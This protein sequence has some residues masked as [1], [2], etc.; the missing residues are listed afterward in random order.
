MSLH[1]V[2]SIALTIAL[3]A[4]AG[5]SHRGASHAPVNALDDT[6]ATPVDA[7]TS[8]GR[9]LFAAQCAACHGAEGSGGPVGAS[10]RGERV[11]KNRA[12]VIAAIESPTPPMPKLFPGTLSSQD[13]ADLAAYVESL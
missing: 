12:A 10:L 6:V 8:H 13:V 5:C 1:R 4:A 3:V 2:V 11:R 9:T 7:S